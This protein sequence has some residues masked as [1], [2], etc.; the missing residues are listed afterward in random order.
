[1]DPTSL[2]APANVA[3]VVLAG[4]EGSRIGG[5]K[6]IRRLAG[7]RLI[8]RALR[9]ARTWSNEVAVAV[10]DPR[11][12]EDVDAPIITDEP[13]IAGPLAG[14]ASALRFGAR[15][16]REFVLTIPADSPFLPADLLDRLLDAV[17]KSNCAMA[18]S[19]G[20]LHPVCAL[21]RTSAT[22]VLQDYLAGDRRSLRAFAAKVG[23]CKVQ[24]GSEPIDP[25]FNI[26]TK[27]ELLRAEELADI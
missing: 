22:S 13:L 27:S 7:E 23:F 5:N 26:N 4:G 11:Q 10:R 8:D 2:A 20:R 18:S 3:V 24:W 19:N 14:L 25:F 15:S 16:G 21:W 17:A 6:P 9:A 1:M 12:L